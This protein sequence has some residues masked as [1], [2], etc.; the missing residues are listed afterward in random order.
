MPSDSYAEDTLVEQTT[1]A[2]LGHEL[3]WEAVYA[4]NTETFEVAG[5]GFSIGCAE[6]CNW[7][8][9]KLAIGR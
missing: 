4:Y 7:P 9:T 3:G 6:S 8:I 1:A 2:Y 5:C